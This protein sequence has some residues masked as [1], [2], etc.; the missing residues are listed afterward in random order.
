VNAITSVVIDLFVK[1][2]I[3]LGFLHRCAHRMS[4]KI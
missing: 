2:A 3:I 1:C 4:W